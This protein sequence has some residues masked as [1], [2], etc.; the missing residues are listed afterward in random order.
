[1]YGDK[2]VL[3]DYINNKMVYIKLVESLYQRIK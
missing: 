2:V 1:M 3:S